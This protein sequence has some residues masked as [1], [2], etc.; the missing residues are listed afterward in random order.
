M[1]SIMQSNKECYLCRKMFGIC[2][3]RGL[4]EH[5]IYEGYGRRRQSEAIGAKVWLCAKHHN[6]S[7]YGIHFNK[8][9]DMELKRACQRKFEETHTREEFMELIGRNYLDD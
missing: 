8:E 3:E 6:M 7:D 2:N 1:K 9:E 5:H 4:H